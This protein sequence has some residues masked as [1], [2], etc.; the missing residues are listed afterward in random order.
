MKLHKRLT[1]FF[2]IL[3][4]IGLGMGD[5]EIEQDWIGETAEAIMDAI[6][7][8]LIGDDGIL[9]VVFNLLPIVGDNAMSVETWFLMAVFIGLLL[10]TNFYIKPMI[11]KS[12]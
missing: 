5:V 11:M 4:I 2:V 1:I 10:F 7:D 3:S 6:A 12:K 8:S 9:M